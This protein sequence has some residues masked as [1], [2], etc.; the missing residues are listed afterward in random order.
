MLTGRIVQLAAITILGLG[1]GLTSVA[2]G[3]PSISDLTR[4]DQ[5][6]MN[7][8]RASIDD[9]ARRSFGD[10]IN[11]NT[12]HDLDVLQRLLD[13]GVVR[14]EQTQLLQAMGMILGDLLAADLDMHWVLYEDSVGRSRALRYRHSEEYL[15]PVTMISRRRE[16][17][18]RKS[19][20]E[21]YQKAYD[22]IDAARPALPFQ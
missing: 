20:A 6:Y 11:G 13:R 5:Q 2:A 8:Q 7:E 22:I 4:L 16:A 18:N 9:L 15:F 14:P 21:I 10:Q 19:V 12:A 3:D 17:G 1:F